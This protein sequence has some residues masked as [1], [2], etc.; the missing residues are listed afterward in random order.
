MGAASAAQLRPLFT[1]PGGS[2]Y[3]V[4]LANSKGWKK[5]HVNVIPA[6]PG[7]GTAKYWAVF[8]TNQDIE[9]E[10]DAVYEVIQTGDGLRVG[11]EIQEQREAFQPVTH[12]DAKVDIL[13]Q[14]YLASVTAGLTL[15]ASP[16]KKA[17]VLR[18][19]DIYQLKTSQIGNKQSDLVVADDQTI[20]TVATGQTLRAGSLIIPW[21]TQPVSSLKFS[22]N[23]TI[24]EVGEDEITDKVAYIT[25]WWVPS[26][27]RTP[28]TTNVTATCPA[29]WELRSEGDLISQE[30]KGDRQTW[31]YQ[32]K[33][34]ISFP[35]VVAGKFILTASKTENGRLFRDYQLEPV[36]ME[37]GQKVVEASAAAVANGDTNLVTFP[38]KG[39]DVFESD[40]YYGIESYSY[41][42]LHKSI[43]LWAT[44]HEIGHTY[45]G[46]LANCPY[47]QDSWNEGLTQ[48]WDSV[49]YKKDN[50]G[51]L[52]GG[53]AS[54]RHAVPLTKMPAPW[55][56]DDASYMRGAYVM[57]MLENELG[58]DSVK[59]GLRYLTTQRI[60]V[61]T[62]WLDLRQVFEKTSG[63]DLG[64]FWDQWVTRAIFPKL[65]VV[66]AHTEVWNNKGQVNVTVRQSGTP[67]P[68][69][70]RFRIVASNGPKTAEKVVT[71]STNQSEFIVPLDF[72]PAQVKVDVFGYTLA[73]VG[74]PVKIASA[75]SPR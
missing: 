40:S 16:A 28:A 57:R 68:Y 22:Y 20:P 59:A 15:K 4:Q 51:T 53:L 48:Y 37:R 9:N 27:G 75:S 13:P 25:A 23:G 60:G 58:L 14:S 49:L 38:F 31:S 19:N 61:P 1:Y 52:R 56:Y 30:T 8:H 74:D 72:G 26:T 5:L 29:D 6:P 54:I 47:V 65:E 17:P 35:K 7:W 41:T 18:L 71:L 66:E 50:D 24:H 45:F 2:D 55:A 62:T 64:W 34:P 73:T 11:S 67:Q 69:H 32:C 44:S 12:I 46:G 36:D 21:T 39:Y 70:L 43:V 63:Q 3:V 33:V 42:L 10:H